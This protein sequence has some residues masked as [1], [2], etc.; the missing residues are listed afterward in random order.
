MVSVIERGPLGPAR[1]A[2]AR[3]RRGGHLGRGRADRAR[4]RDRLLPA[5]RA[6]LRRRRMSRGRRSV[7]AA[8]VGKRYALG[9]AH[10]RLQ[11]ADRVALRADALAGPRDVR[12][13]RTFW[14]LRDVG[15]EVERGETFGIIGHNGAGKSTL[16]KIL[17][18]VTPPTEGEVRLEGRVGALLEVGTGFHP[19]LTGRENIFLNGA[20]L[21]MERAEIARKFDEIVEFA[22]VERFIDTPVKRYSSGMQLRLAFCGRR[23]PGARDPDRRRGA[24]GRRPRVPGEVPG[25]DGGGG[26]RGPDRA[27]RQPQPHGGVEPVPALDAARV[28]APR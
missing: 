13:A 20:I 7:H 28:A 22:E 14:A 18:R 23:A 11:A 27:V 4:R 16:L 24:L 17:S 3:A 26:R 1:G 19:E 10:R 12:H 9:R 2:R 15:F 21:G 25:P 5:D 8:G 6:L